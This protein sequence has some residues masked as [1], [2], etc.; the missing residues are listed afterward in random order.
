MTD[1]PY[2]P[3]AAIAADDEEWT[4]EGHEGQT[5]DPDAPE[6]LEARRAA[7]DPTALIGPDPRSDEA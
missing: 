2:A 3:E 1:N 4:L 6:V 7:N 5:L